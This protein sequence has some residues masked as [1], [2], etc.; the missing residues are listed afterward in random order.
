[1][2]NIDQGQALDV[3]LHTS[4][5]STVQP[6]T[7]SLTQGTQVYEA[8]AKDQAPEDALRR[9]LVHQSAFKQCTGEA[10]YVDDLPAVEGE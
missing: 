5:L 8:A 10:I 9:P 6:V 1:M 4:Y 3:P 2:V 7:P